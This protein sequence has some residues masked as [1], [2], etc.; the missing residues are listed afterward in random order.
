MAGLAALQEMKVEPA[1]CPARPEI[2]L[3]QTSM[4]RQQTPNFP[5]V[6]VTQWKG[7]EGKKDWKSK[8]AYQVLQLPD[9]LSIWINVN[10][11]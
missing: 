8:R 11:V 3:G 9:C 10:L 1:S 7:V 6:T 5:P 2:N 4:Y